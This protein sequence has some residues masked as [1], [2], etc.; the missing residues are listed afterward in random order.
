MMK[1]ILYLSFLSA[2]VLCSAQNV[3]ARA[4]LEAENVNEVR[5][6]GSFV[7]VYVKKGDAV[8]FEGIITGSGDEGD[9][10][11]DTDIVGSSL[12]IKVV[13]ERDFN[14]GNYRIRE[15]R[16]DVT[17]TDGVKLDIENS[18]GDV[19]VAN[20]RASEAEIETTSGDVKLRSIVSNL[21]LETT[22]GDIDIDGLTGD[23]EIESTS[24]DQDLYNLKGDI[25]TRASSGDITIGSFNGRLDVETTSGDVEIRGGKGRL[26][27][28]TTSGNIDGEGIL[29][30]GDAS[31]DA[32]SGDIEIDFK[33][34]LDELS[35]DLRATSGDLEVGSRSAEKRLTIDRGGI[36]VTGVTSAGNQEYE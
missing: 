10:R 19:Q 8:R 30:T 33:N 16:I 32:T 17:I 22:S 12:V 15:S 35:F 31:F 13:K 23:S 25:N 28:Q 20:L 27:I 4:E 21:Q 36:K 11:F 1:T 7:D 6:E 14:W 3:L 5:I 9:Y 2:A 26:R 29:L 24:G 34:D 18:S